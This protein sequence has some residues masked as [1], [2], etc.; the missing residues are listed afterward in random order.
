MSMSITYNCT[1]VAFAM[2]RDSSGARKRTT[3]NWWDP[4]P[5]TGIP[6]SPLPVQA[7]TRGKEGFE[8]ETCCAMP[9]IHCSWRYRSLSASPDDLHGHPHVRGLLFSN[10]HSRLFDTGPEDA[11]ESIARALGAFALCAA[12]FKERTRTSFE[13]T[14]KPKCS[15]RRL[16]RRAVAQYIGHFSLSS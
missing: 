12:R 15:V 8:H 7:C 11:R 6:G 3:L 16:I 13:G 9:C 4:R 2:V 10:R 5:K 14:A 1:E